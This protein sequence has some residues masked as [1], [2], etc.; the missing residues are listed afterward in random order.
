M[1]DGSERDG[2]PDGDR[3]LSFARDERRDRD[4]IGPLAH[5]CELHRGAQ[6]AE[7]LLQIGNRLRGHQRAQWALAQRPHPRDRREH[8][9]VEPGSGFDGRVEGAAGPRGDE[10]DEHGR[11]HAEHRRREQERSLV[12]A[13][14]GF[15][16]GR[17][18][19]DLD[20]DEAGG[21]IGVVRRDR[22]EPVGPVDRRLGIVR[23][24]ADPH[25]AG[26][27]LDFG[28]HLD[29]LV[30]VLVR[31]CVTR[32]FAIGSRLQLGDDRRD[33]E[34]RGLHPALSATGDGWVGLDAQGRGRLVRLVGRVGDIDADQDAYE[35]GRGGHQPVPAQRDSQVSEFHLV[36]AS[37]W[38]VRPDFLAPA[39]VRAVPCRARDG[40]SYSPSPFRARSGT[41]LHRICAFRSVRGRE[42]AAR[43]HRCTLAPSRS[44]SSGCC[45]AAA[46]TTSRTCSCSTPTASRRHPSTR[47][48]S[49]SVR[50]ISG[51]TSTPSP[52][53]G[54]RR[55][56]S[57][58]ATGPGCSDPSATGSSGSCRKVR[59]RR[60]VVTKTPRLE[61][62]DLYFDLFPQAPLLILVR[63]GRN[64]VA[65]NAAQ[66]RPERGGSS[67][68]VGGGRAGG[69]GV[70]R[71]QPESWAAVSRR[72]LRGPRRGS[73]SDDDGHLADLRPRRVA[74]TTSRPRRR[75][76]CVA[77][78][79]SARTRTACTGSRSR[80]TT[81]S[82]P[83]SAGAT[84]RRTST[85]GSR[86]WRVRCNGRWA[87]TSS[88]P[89][90]TLGDRVRGGIDDATW[91]LRR[92]R[93]RFR[94]GGH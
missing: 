30:G 23:L 76:R 80:R 78:R 60:R 79:R 50:A 88:R 53:V 3:G 18:L 67:S 29:P 70:R 43:I 2:E 9:Q 85:R 22:R 91:G 61:N 84:G 17:E 1:A 49:S 81:R 12:V 55:G 6:L 92:L 75:C 39:S 72:P 82:G 62:L 38:P 69:D 20:R 10:R 33:D 42:G 5:E 31:E 40:T 19:E 37:P 89:R 7:R 86:R 11:Q 13:G 35:K 14:R 90:A 24:D 57:R 15:G 87:T 54:L 64:V 41:R 46:R 63:D 25:D 93:R 58:R 8:G 27:G 26:A 73:R 71:A 68:G 21:P 74:L 94:S 28:A 52:A 47:T 77:H 59:A 44:S 48:T 83:M 34:V 4:D 16:V 36:L 66:L 45:A 65:S 32:G 51:G 56:G